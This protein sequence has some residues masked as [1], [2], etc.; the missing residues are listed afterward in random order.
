MRCDIAS[1]IY[2]YF[3]VCVCI[4]QCMRS[5]LENRSLWT[6]II[7]HSLYADINGNKTNVD[8]LLVTNLNFWVSVKLI[9]F[10]IIFDDSFCSHISRSLYIFSHISRLIPL[11]F[12]SSFWYDIYQSKASWSTYETIDRS[13][14][15]DHIYGEI[16]H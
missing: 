3:C 14:M 9:R 2:L 1:T 6:K 12:I 8:T 16:L 5:I 10:T 4:V 7:F 15:I 11:S 13:H